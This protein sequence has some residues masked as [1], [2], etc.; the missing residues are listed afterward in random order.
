MSAINVIEEDTP[1]KDNENKIIET[2]EVKEEVKEEKQEEVINENLEAEKERISALSFSSYDSIDNIKL[3][4]MGQ[5]TCNKCS[6]IPKIISTDLKDKS[7]LFKCKE[8]GL[9]KEPLKDFMLN[10]LNYTTKNWKCSQCDKIQRNDKENFL[11]CQCAEVFCSACYKIH[12]EG[13]KH[14]NT[15]ESDKFN[16]RCR[17]SPD[18]FDQKFIGYCY[19]CSMHYCKKCEQSEKHDLHAVTPIDTMVVNDKEIDKIRKINKEYRSLISYYESLIRL[20]NLIIYSY[21]NY[22]S[23]Y[24]NCFNINAII[25][26]YNRNDYI[27]S[28]QDIESIKIIPGEKNVNLTNYMKDLFKQEIED[29]KT[30]SLDI[31][32]KYCNNLDFQVL[33]QIPIKN[34]HVLNLENNCI[35]NIDCITGADFPELVVLNLNNNAIVDISHFEG[36]KFQNE[37]QAL[38]LRNNNIKD[39]SVFG[40]SKMDYLREL[41]LRNNKIDDI[42]AFANHKLEFLQCLYLSYNDFDPKDKK[43]DKA[44]ERMKKELIEYELE[45]E[46]TE[47]RVEDTS[48][49][50]EEENQNANQNANQNDNQNANEDPNQIIEESGSAI[51]ES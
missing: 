20:N 9:N 44:V 3:D 1:I 34:L 29:E 36:C 30:D 26:N 19:D 27:K 10:C 39:I 33:T 7:I 48:S 43:F 4:K 24:Y 6:E 15:I 45:P 37:L 42:N 21:Q 11:Y 35:S 41:D 46:K 22:R 51:E 14:F 49:K 17:V 32:S 13:L 2:E 47:S 50:I 12:K 28:K 31:D 18:H 23:N 5:Y 16:L 8:H 25:N 40:K 38:L